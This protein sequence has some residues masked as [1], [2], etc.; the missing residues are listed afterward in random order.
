MKTAKF[1]AFAAIVVGALCALAANYG[2]FADVQAIT[3]AGAPTD[4]TSGTG[5]GVARPGSLLVDTTNKDLYINTNTAASPTWSVLAIDDLSATELG[6]LDGVTAGTAAA[7]KAVVLGASGEI[8]TIT[9]GTIATLNTTNVDAGASGTAGTVDVFPST[10]S[11]G[12]LAITAADSAGDTTTTIVNASQAGARTYTIPDAGGTGTFVLSRTGV[13][14]DAPDGANLQTYSAIAT[15]FYGDVGGTKPT[16]WTSDAETGNC[17]ADY[18]ANE[19]FGALALATSADDEAQAVQVTW[20]DNLM[21]DLD[22]DPILEV[23]A[24]IDG[25]AD[26][27]SVEKV[28]IGVIPAHANAEDNA[29][30]DNVD[31]SAWFLVKGDNDT[32]IYVETD[33]AA[34]DTDDQDST[35]TLTDDTWTVFR[36]DF[37]TLSAVS[38]TVDGVEQ[39][40]AA[41]DFSGAAGQNV[42]PI[43]LIQRTDNTQT[44]A[45]VG[46]EVD[47]VKVIQTR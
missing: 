26:L 10:A 28:V 11:K 46:V 9:T 32:K 40:G 29:G 1:L 17:S 6:Y 19:P 39:G 37:S 44:E 7:S 4:G 13:G 35:I 38:M 36:I 27:E 12:K 2:P 16:P 20:G 15:D 5:A 18:M 33:D 22:Q 45:I 8:A 43:V 14:F 21:I 3:N 25:V 34:T 24:R 31:Y 47:Y 30:L 41:L 23:R 42:Q